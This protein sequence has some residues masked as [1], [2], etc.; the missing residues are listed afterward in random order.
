MNLLAHDT[1]FQALRQRYYQYCDQV[2][3]LADDRED[4]TAWWSS[5]H[6]AQ[7]N[8]IQADEAVTNYLINELKLA[9]WHYLT[10]ILDK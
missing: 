8:M 7:L 10:P 5:Y 6:Q 1:K 2:H 9:I 4:T 3:T